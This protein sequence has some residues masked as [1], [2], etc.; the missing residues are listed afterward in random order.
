MRRVLLAA[1]AAAI[2]LSTSSLVQAQTRVT[3]MPAAGVSATGERFA[4]TDEDRIIMRRYVRPREQY[5]MTTG[6]AAGTRV[7]PG[8]IFLCPKTTSAFPRAVIHESPHLRAYRYIRS[9]NAAYVVDPRTR[10][11]IEEIS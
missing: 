5:G 10:M 1:A 4:F 2:A 8:S 9:G 6:S 11:V 7:S 3:S